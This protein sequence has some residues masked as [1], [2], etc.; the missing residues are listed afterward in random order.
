M[1][2]S[3]CCEFFAQRQSL[4]WTADIPFQSSDKDNYRRIL[5]QHRN[6][7]KEFYSVYKSSHSGISLSQSNHDTA[8]DL[9]LIQGLKW[10]PERIRMIET[11]FHASMTNTQ[12]CM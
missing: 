2:P 6:S 8:E 11:Y 9:I 12:F 10:Q 7:Q 1:A 4:Y 5:D 3:C